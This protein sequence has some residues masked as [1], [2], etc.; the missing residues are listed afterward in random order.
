MEFTEMLAQD[1]VIKKLLNTPA[2]YEQSID[3]RVS[4]RRIF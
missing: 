3:K 2:V 1:P 4:L